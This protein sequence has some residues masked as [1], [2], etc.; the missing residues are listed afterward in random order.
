AGDEGD[1]EEV[2]R[3]LMYGVAVEMMVVVDPSDER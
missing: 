2:T 3:V 1:V